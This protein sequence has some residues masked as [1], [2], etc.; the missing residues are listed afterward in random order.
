MTRREDEIE[1]LQ[2]IIKQLQRAQFGR[3]SERLDPD[4][5]ALA[6]EDLNGD[7]GFAE[8][9]D[10]LSGPPVPED[11][12][13]SETC[14]GTSSRALP[15]HL[16]RRDIVLDAGHAAC[17]DCGGVLH[18]AGESVSEMLDWVPAELRVLRIRRPKYG[19]RDCGRIHQA[20]AP[21]RPIARGLATPALLSHVLISKYC[22][23]TP[24]YRQTRIFARHGIDLKRSTL[25]N[26]VGGACWWFEALHDRLRQH[27]LTSDQLFADDTPLPVL[28]PGRGRTRTGRL[29]VMSTCH[30]WTLTQT[31]KFATDFINHFV[32]KP[33]TFGYWSFAA[34][35][36]GH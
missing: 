7:L 1:R 36:G 6:L 24:L 9:A 18:A 20:H 32:K 12:G 14:R 35:I 29:W 10:D 8:T 19:C 26:W 22:D 13:G 16:P 31:V 30:K 17:P 28:D 11:N 15:D 27:I 33:M 2:Q 4:Q 5:M 25:A 34:Q 21:E 3:R 23:H